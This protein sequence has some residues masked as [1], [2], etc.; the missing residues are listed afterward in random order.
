MIK[1][2]KTILDQYKVQA[3][4]DT[5][6]EEIDEIKHKDFIIERLLQNGGLDG[7]NWLFDK[8]DL[9][10]LKHVIMN[11]RFISIRTACFWSVYF[12][13]PTDNFFQI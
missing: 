11:S 3:F 9:E 5:P 10:K 12:S 13:I 2:F 8:Y 7:V 6:L 1:E 4:R